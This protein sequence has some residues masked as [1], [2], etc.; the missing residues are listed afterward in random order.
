MRRQKSD[1][2]IAIVEPLPI[3]TPTSAAVNANKSLICH[4]PIVN[5]S[6]G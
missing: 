5:R 3:E 1:V 4:K 6:E 2:E